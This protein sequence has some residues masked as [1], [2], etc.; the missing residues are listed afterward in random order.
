MTGTGHRKRAQGEPAHTHAP[1]KMPPIMAKTPVRKWKKL[2][3]RS[4]NCTRIGE[5]S[6]ITN[7][8][9]IGTH[10]NKSRAK[11]QEAQKKK[12]KKKKK[13]KTST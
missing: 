12:K 2:C 9:A 11:P 7:R 3:V 6:N 4:L 1:E 8:P 5:I 13:K 10:C